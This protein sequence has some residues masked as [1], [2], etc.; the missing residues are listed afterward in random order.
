MVTK[1][2][3]ILEKLVEFYLNNEFLEVFVCREMTEHFYI[4]QDTTIY[5]DC[6]HGYKTDELQNT[7]FQ[8]LTVNHTY[9]FVDPQTGAH[10]QNIIRL[11]GSSKWLNK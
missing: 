7:R 3:C 6:L 9:N 10:T 4:N 5:S 8:H 2:E 11:W 1:L